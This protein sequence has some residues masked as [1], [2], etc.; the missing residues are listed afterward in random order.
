MSEWPK[1]RL[2]LVGVQRV[3]KDEFYYEISQ[4]KLAEN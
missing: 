2:E 3:E 4:E 1:E